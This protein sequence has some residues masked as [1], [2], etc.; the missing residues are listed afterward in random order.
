MAHDHILYDVITDVDN[1][2]VSEGIEHAARGDHWRGAPA[3]L[4]R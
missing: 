2:V 1:D 4:V 3:V